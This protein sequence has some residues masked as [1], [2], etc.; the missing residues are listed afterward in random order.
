MS[1]TKSRAKPI[2][3]R[4]MEKITV[5]EYG[6]WIWSG[7]LHKKGHGLI[8]MQ[9]RNGKW[10]MEMAHKVAYKVF[11]GEIAKG[12]YVIQSCDELRCCNPE[13]LWLGTAEDRKGLVEVACKIEGANF[14][15]RQITDIRSRMNVAASRETGWVEQIAKALMREYGVSRKTID[16]IC[17]GKF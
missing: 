10:A 15:V 3:D 1:E 9:K 13:H 8:N 11:L 6:C 16:D 17:S 7:G 12:L 5:D 2:R 14:T 4:L